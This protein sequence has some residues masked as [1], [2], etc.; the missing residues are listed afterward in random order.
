MVI[1]TAEQTLKWYDFYIV[2][3]SYHSGHY[4][5]TWFKP[6]SVVMLR[7]FFVSNQQR[8]LGRKLNNITTICSV[9]C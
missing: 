4:E 7:F 6:I 2:M 5:M 8:H 3:L 9:F 1:I